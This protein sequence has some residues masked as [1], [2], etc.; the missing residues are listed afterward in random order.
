MVHAQAHSG[1]DNLTLQAEMAGAALGCHFSSSAEYEAAL[2]AERRKAGAY[3]L[4]LQRRRTTWVLATLAVFS[5][6]LFW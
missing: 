1:L 6:A 3:R 5:F 4:P 2:V